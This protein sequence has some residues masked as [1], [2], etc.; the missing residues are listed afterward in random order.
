MKKL[1]A[2]IIL[3]FV[4]ISC[5]KQKIY[6][7]SVII[8]PSTIDTIIVDKKD[9]VSETDSTFKIIATIPAKNII[10]DN[11]VTEKEIKKRS[12]IETKIFKEKEEKLAKIE[13]DNFEEKLKAETKAYKQEL[14]I[15]VKKEKEKGKL[16]IRK[17]LLYFIIVIASIIIIAF[18]V[19]I[20]KRF[21]K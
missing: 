13:I 17:I 1:P 11:L 20:L 14:K 16:T 6:D 5:H 2:F 12:K 18:I 7:S 10:I 9:I 8:I 21:K 19:F 4:C 15:E 3:I